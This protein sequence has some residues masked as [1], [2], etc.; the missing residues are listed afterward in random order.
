M[1]AG[2]AIA[3]SSRR[4]VI[5]A[6][7]ALL[8]A[9]SWALRATPATRPRAAFGE[10]AFDAAVA[11]LTD[12]A[13]PTAT[14]KVRIGVARLAENGAVVPLKIEVELPDA[15]AIAILATKNPVPLVARFDLPAGTLGFIATRIKLAESSEV[16]ALI[17][18]AAGWYMA[19]QAVEVTIGGCS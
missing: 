15:R 8:V 2:S 17:D 10:E 16:V 9:P 7:A 3:P 19:R 11:E 6:F 13:T 12:H 4:T 1:P 18:T 14:D 5:K